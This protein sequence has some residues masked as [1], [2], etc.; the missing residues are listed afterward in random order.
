MHPPSVHVGRRGP[1]HRTARICFVAGT[2]GRGGAERQ[3]VYILTALRHAG[4]ETRVLCLTTGQPYERQI[5]EQGI[6]VEWVGKDS[7][8]IARLRSIIAAVRREPTDVVQSTH[9]YTNH[10]ASVAASLVGAKSIGAVRG[11]LL[12]AMRGS[13]PFGVAGLFM[14]DYLV[15][16]S[17]PALED[18]L[19]R[20]RSAERIF[21]L[22]NVIDTG[23][24]RRTD[25][26][27][28]VRDADGIRLL[29]VGRLTHEKRADRF[30][31]L[32]HGVRLSLPDRRVQACIA[33]DGPDRADLEVL[34]S[35]LG[36]HPEDLHFAGE[37]EDTQPLYDWAD[38]LVLTSDHEGTPNVILEAMATGVPVVATAVGGV[39][40]LLRH[41]GGLAI[42]REDED[43]LIAAVIRLS[44]DAR[45][46]G[47]LTAEGSR[48]LERNHSAAGLITR[49][50]DM[51]KTVAPEKG[52]GVIHP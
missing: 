34:G 44:S 50:D 52:A 4:V 3:L 10:Y 11:N 31:R 2:L 40:D 21:L 5:E 15:V 42:R 33:G 28:T 41:G 32:V 9:F 22:E 25:R 18:A 17:R 1:L 37:V 47:D 12:E 46:V 16:N 29:F 27:S 24:F 7:S 30:L 14:P 49:L 20:G 6:A 51:Y 39:P 26:E 23:R 45:L 48:Y 35:S 36:L 19:G 38:I 13:R 43:A 8:R